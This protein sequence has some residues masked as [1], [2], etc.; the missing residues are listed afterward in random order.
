M[1][2]GHPHQRNQCPG[3]RPQVCAQSGRH[4][5]GVGGGQ[6]SGQKWRTDE[7]HQGDGA[8]DQGAALEHVRSERTGG[9][10]LFLP[11]S[12]INGDHSGEQRLGQNILGIA[13]ETLGQRHQ[14]GVCG[15][16]EDG[17]HHLA[18][19]AQDLDED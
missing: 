7:Q 19:K 5:R 17:R 8:G 13:H 9:G 11:Q 14:I 12:H 10:R 18:D 1:E 3:K 2:S 6:Q 15:G 16:A 4:D